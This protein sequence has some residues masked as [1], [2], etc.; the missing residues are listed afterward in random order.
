MD[1]VLARA[2]VRTPE[3][4]QWEEAAAAAK[5]AETPVEDESPGLTAH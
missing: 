3:P 2:L 1:E 4:I 5:P